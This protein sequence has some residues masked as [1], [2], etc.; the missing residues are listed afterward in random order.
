MSMRTFRWLLA[1]TFMLVAAVACSPA[2]TTPSPTPTPTPASQPGID[3]VALEAEIEKAITTGPETLDKVRA[4]LVSVDGETK[5]AHYRHGFT[6]DDHGHVFSVT[7]SVLS[8]LIGI[9]IADGLIADIDQP[10]AKLLPEHRKAMSG[11]TAKVTLRHLMTMSAGFNNQFPGGFVWEEYAK[12]GRSFVNLLLERRQNFEPGT[13]FWYSDVSAHLVAAVLTAAL[14]RADGDR[15]RTVLDYAR[16]KLFDPLGISSSPAFS[17]ALPDPFL[18]TEFVTAG[19]GW[20][21]DPNG[22]QLGG[23]GLRLTAPDMMKIG[24]LYRRD[25]VWN[26]E[27]IVSSAWIQQCTSPATYETKIGGPSDD[28]YGLLWWIIGKPKPAGYYALG[29]GG[30]LTV[31]LPKSRAVIVYLTDVQPGS[32]IDGKDLEPLDNVLISAFPQ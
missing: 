32:E 23:Y 5:I 1:T 22:I 9:A 30:Q 8:I 17:Q 18:T 10:L 4:V 16:Q 15:P 28:E 7:K 25:G 21:T 12:P 31:V 6:E 11:D 3:Y 2:A 13:V 24:E 27:Q 14:E 20:G 19:F 29:F 26:G